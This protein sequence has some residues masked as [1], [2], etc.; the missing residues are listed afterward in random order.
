MALVVQENGDTDIVAH[1]PED[2]RENIEEARDERDHDQRP[3]LAEHKEKSEGFNRAIGRWRGHEVEHVSG[4]R[5][6][7]LE[8]G[9]GRGGGGGS[10]GGRGGRRERGRVGTGTG[11][12]VGV[13][14]FP[15]AVASLGGGLRGGRGVRGRRRGGRYGN[16]GGGGGVGDGRAGVRRGARTCGYTACIQ[17]QSSRV[18]RCWNGLVPMLMREV[19]VCGQVFV[20]SKLVHR[21]AEGHTG[22]GGQLG[23]SMTTESPGMMMTMMM[24]Q[25]V[26]PIV[27]V[28]GAGWTLTGRVSST[29]GVHRGQ[30][31]GKCAAGR[32]A[33]DIMADVALA[34][35]NSQYR[36]V[37]PPTQR[38]T[39]ARIHRLH[40]SINNLIVL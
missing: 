23:A 6:G 9:D 5:D 4:F 16:G 24:K 8:D 25:A 28:E 29:A 3:D 7:M 11:G 32:D 37:R 19:V 14:S 33:N 26:G 15:L 1:A 38:S 22:A 12:S 20:G 21:G 30:G 27:N 39:G 31:D 17:R 36:A 13:G 40:Q 2:K 18:G 35:G 34:I 10:H